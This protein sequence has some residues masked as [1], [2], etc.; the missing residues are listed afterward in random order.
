MKRHNLDSE[1]WL[2]EESFNSASGYDMMKRILS[3][4]ERPTAVFAASDAI[5]IGAM[6]AISEA[7]LSI[8]KD[9]SIIGFNDV[10]ACKYTT[11]ALTSI[12]APAY[13]MGAHG[14]NLVYVS[15]NLQI[16]TPLK[17]KIPCELIKRESCGEV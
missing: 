2:L 9:I 16:H 15:S 5:A 13:D 1:S 14:A 11:P 7:G 3:M 8:P 10:E 17:V 6:R 12:H 4:E